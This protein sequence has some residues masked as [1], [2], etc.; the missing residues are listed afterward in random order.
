VLEAMATGLPV[1]CVDIGGPSISVRDDTGFRVSPSCRRSMIDAMANHIADYSKN[2]KLVED[3]G[4]NARESVAAHFD[5]T[6]KGEM[7]NEIYQSVG[8]GGPAASISTSTAG[9]LFFPRS[10]RETK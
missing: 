1:I 10:T 7:K 5:W 8:R 2:R 6:R 3:H 9:G 4:R